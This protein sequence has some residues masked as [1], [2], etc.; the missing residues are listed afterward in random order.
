[1]KKNINLSNLAFQKGIQ[2]GGIEISGTGS[3]SGISAITR[4]TTCVAFSAP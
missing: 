1:M 2:D 4:L 3:P